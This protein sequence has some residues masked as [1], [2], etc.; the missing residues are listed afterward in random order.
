MR[1]L[2]LVLPLALVCLIAA[3]CSSDSEDSTPSVAATEPPVVQPTEA[4]QAPAETPTQAPA[5]PVEEATEV[6]E[7]RPIGQQ[8]LADAIYAAMIEDDERPSVVSEEQVRC[9]AY[10]L[11]GVFSDERL[12]E[13]GLNGPSIT[14]VYEDRGNVALFSE[15]GISEAEASELVDRALECLDWRGL[16]AEEVASEGL[17]PDQADC[18]ASEISGEGIRAVVMNALIL[19]SEDDL[20]LREE[21]VLAAL[22]ACVDVRDMLFQ[23]FVQEG[24]SEQSARCVAEGLPEELVEIMLEGPEIE[25]EEAALEFIGELMAL[26]NRCLTPEEIESMG[27]FGG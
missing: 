2:K 20:G 15:F 25:D 16:V 27:G 9:L 24:L 13:L 12:S 14:S 11:A 10:D 26:Q 8:E 4:V 18:I 6:S 22:Q 17:P 19:E 7:I 21:E 3:A 1:F 23:T 5:T